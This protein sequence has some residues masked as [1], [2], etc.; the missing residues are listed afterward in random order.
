MAANRSAPTRTTVHLFPK[1]EG[2]ILVVGDKPD[3]GRVFTDL[4][5]ALDAAT[6]SDRQV[7]VVVHE[8][9]AA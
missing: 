1:A 8:A 7:H 3:E 4:G 5:G 2:W 9:G 6:N